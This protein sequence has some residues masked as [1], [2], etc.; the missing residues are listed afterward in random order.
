MTANGGGFPN[1]IWQSDHLGKLVVSVRR[2]IIKNIRIGLT[3]VWEVWFVER[4]L[5]K[6]HRNIGTQNYTSVQFGEVS[7]EFLGSSQYQV[8]GPTTIRWLTASTVFALGWWF[9][10]VTCSVIEVRDVHTFT[11]G[12]MCSIG[13]PWG[14]NIRLINSFNS[15][16]ESDNLGIHE[17]PYSR[18]WS[19]RRGRLLI[20]R[21]LNSSIEELYR[22]GPS[23][24]L[25]KWDWAHCQ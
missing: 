23:E 6:R 13:K 9:E 16:C 4:M 10:L 22:R 18:V 20:S 12:R 2:R 25:L 24:S 21:L 17:T 8:H 1:K 11:I 7:K 15:V 14:T 5:F 19:V 3:P